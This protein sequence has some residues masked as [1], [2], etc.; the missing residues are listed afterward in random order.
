MVHT[1]FTLFYLGL[2]LSHGIWAQDV[3]PSMPSIWAT[4]GPV[5]LQGS[6]V[7]IFCGGPPGTTQHHLN[8]AGSSQELYKE[9]PKE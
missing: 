9:E 7:S 2:H 4:P 6:T 1:F 3:T 5:V 8:Q